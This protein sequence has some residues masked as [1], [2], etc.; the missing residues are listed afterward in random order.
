MAMIGSQ[1]AIRAAINPARPTPPTP[2]TA[3]D[4]PAAGRITFST[5]PAP[6]CKPQPRRPSISIGASRRILMT[7]L[8]GATAK[9][10]NEDC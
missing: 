2:Y 10:A 4:C 8:A 6:V 1:P 7:S 3:I 5:A 9:F